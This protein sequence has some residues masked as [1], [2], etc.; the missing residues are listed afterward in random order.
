[1]EELY[2]RCMTEVPMSFFFTTV[3]GRIVE[4]KAEHLPD[5]SPY[6]LKFS[7]TTNLAIMEPLR[8]KREV[9][10]ILPA[11]VLRYLQSTVWSTP[12]AE[13]CGGSSTD[14]A[15]DPRFVPSFLDCF[16]LLK[17]QSVPEI[18]SSTRPSNPMINFRSF[19]LLL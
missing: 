2:H 3:T 13:K 19:K 8:A 7:N 12:G 14:G 18:A 9:S 6:S 16:V 17:G 11:N 5:T 4:V 15:C 1:M 10:T